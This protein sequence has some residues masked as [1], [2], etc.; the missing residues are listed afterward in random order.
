MMK[1]NSRAMGASTA[2]PN[3]AVVGRHI[4]RAWFDTVLNPLLRALED[5]ERLLGSKNWTWQFRPGGLES[6]RNVRTHVP[7]EARDNLEQFVGFYP[8][9]GTLMDAHDNKVAVLGQRC[10]RLQEALQDSPDLRRLYEQVTSPAS[11]TEIGTT[12]ENV[13]GAY[14]VS[15]HVAL[16]AQYI[17]NNT[18]DLPDYYYTAPLWNKH[19]GRFL[20]ILKQ[21]SILMHSLVTDKAGADLLKSVRL[22]YRVLK[23]KRLKLSLEYDV[24]Y[25]TASRSFSEESL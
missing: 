24:P 1:R 6:V 15:D 11:L 22:L 23:E 2:K 18:G 25:V 10:G 8:G 7:F 21:R 17:V 16:L 12:L 9:V 19:R 20:A 14:P 13:F 5:E 4:V 3:K